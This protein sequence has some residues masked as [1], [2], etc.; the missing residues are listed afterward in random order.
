MV[1]KKLD[2]MIVKISGRTDYEEMTRILFLFLLET[3]INGIFEYDKA[4][5]SSI[6]L[7][8]NVVSH[9]NQLC[10]CIDN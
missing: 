4:F 8:N 9:L 3:T 2:V 6:F 10:G 5:T 1:E 7:K